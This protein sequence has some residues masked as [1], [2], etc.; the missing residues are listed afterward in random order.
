MFLMTNQIHL[1]YKE[2]IN[3]GAFYTPKNYIYI[4]WNKIKKFI[5]NNSIVL[6]SSC[7]YGNF[8]DIDINI[9]SN[10][11]LIANDIDKIAYKTTKN[12]FQNINIFNKNA[13]KDVSRAMFNI[14]NNK[15]LIII[16]NP[17]YN[18]ITSIIRNSIKTDSVNIDSDIKTRDYGISFLLSY[19][20]LDADVVCVLHPLSYLVKRANFKLLKNFTKKYKL[21][22]STIIDSKTFK[23]TSKGISFPIVIALY[24]KDKNGMD[25]N[26]IQNF[27]FKTIDNKKFKL[28][29][30]DYISNYIRKYPIKNILP[31]K[32]DI[33]FWT[34]RDINALKRNRTFIQNFGYN[35]I[36][37]DKTKL[38]YYVYV[39]VFKQ[40]SKVIPYYFG[41]LDVII[42][43]E[44]FIKYKKYFIQE[45]L[46]RWDF[47][48]NY[49]TK[50]KFDIQL[51]RGKIVE[52]FKELI[53]E[54]YVY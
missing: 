26:Y 37:L 20:K 7:G 35:T 36:I 19:A 53:G 38:D 1:N 41:N 40:Y 46:N 45:A 5:D 2:K 12:N 24:Q 48:K 39:D 23:E 9:N 52:Y 17:P 50:E 30:F 54:H 29:Q 16:G 31:Q 18:D 14:E 11:Q 3:L 42:D 43:N 51:V 6:D 33:L 8:F 22:D 21:I 44:L 4:V 15:K 32:D 49:Y 47:L 13:L 25:Y 28:N 10:F 27:E 34:M